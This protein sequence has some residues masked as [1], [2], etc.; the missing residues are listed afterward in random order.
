MNNKSLSIHNSNK[1]ICPCS[2]F[3]FLLS[4]FCC[5]S[6]G[7]FRAKK[8]T[9]SIAV[10]AS[11]LEGLKGEGAKHR[12]IAQFARAASIFRMSEIVVIDDA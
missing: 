1:I 2:A 11:V 3:F 4:S 6:M 8:R 9:I 7:P 5:Y 10:C 12:V